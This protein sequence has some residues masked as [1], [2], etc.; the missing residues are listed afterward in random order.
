MRKPAP[1]TP[2][3]FD[4]P[5]PGAWDLERAHMTGPVTPFMGPI[6]AE[7][8]AKGIADCMRRYGSLLDYIEL[9]VSNSFLYSRAQPVGAP[10]G[11]TG[12]PPKLVIQLLTRLHPAMRR[13]VRISATLFDR[14]PWRDELREW[15]E[16]V[17]PA[18]IR[19]N[20]ELVAV[21]PSKLAPEAFAE[22]LTRCRENVLRMIVQHHRFMLA[23]TVAV[24]DLFAHLKAWTNLPAEDLPW[25]L[26]GFSPI[27][28]NVTEQSQRLRE[29]LEKDPAARA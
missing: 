1:P 25:L 23:G 16:Q 24:G 26:E 22:H 2:H 21:E 28:A 13:R 7:G 10:R 11:A 3:S 9:G 18:T 5:G 17:K 20:L 15:D 29:A 4:P 14:K 27:S 19:A 6:F 8:M 12:T